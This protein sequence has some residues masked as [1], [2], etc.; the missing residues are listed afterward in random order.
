MCSQRMHAQGLLGAANAP[1]NKQEIGPR[2][3]ASLLA[4][5]AAGSIG[6]NI[7]G[8]LSVRSPK[9]EKV[10][11]NHSSMAVRKTLQTARRPRT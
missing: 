11:E 2:L 7:G 8:K 4:L 3:L 5:R 1:S 6:V 9:S 10:A